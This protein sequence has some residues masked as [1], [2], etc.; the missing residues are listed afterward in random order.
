MIIV[1]WDTEFTSWEDAQERAWSGTGEA[2]EIIQLAARKLNIANGEIID[3][4]DIFVKPIKNP[5]LSD[6]I[7]ELTSI[8]Q[9]QIDKEGISFADAYKIFKEFIEDYP[10]FSFGEDSKI[11]Q[12]CCD[13]NSITYDIRVPFIDA[14]VYFKNYGIDVRKYTSGTIAKAFGIELGGHVHQAMHDVNSLSLALIELK[15]QKQILVK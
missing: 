8:T 13:L 4:I 12:E 1:V 5:I 9:K 11:L 2:R 14:R 15:K 7:Q 3:E 10:C 6:F